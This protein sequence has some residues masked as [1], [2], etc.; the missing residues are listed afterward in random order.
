MGKSKVADSLSQL[1]LLETEENVY[2]EPYGYRVLLV[3]MH[4][5]QAETAPEESPPESVSVPDKQDVTPNPEVAEL[6]GSQLDTET[7]KKKTR[8]KWNLFK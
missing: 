3:T 8:Q 5:L 4:D 7:L 1:P 6:S 2:V